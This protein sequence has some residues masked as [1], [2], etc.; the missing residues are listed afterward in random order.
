MPSHAECTRIG[1]SGPAGLNDSR[2][3]L[4]GR[5]GKRHVPAVVL[6]FHLVFWDKFQSGRVHTPPL[7]SALRRSVVEDV[8]TVR[9]GDL[10]THFGS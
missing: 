2:W 4:S 6:G 10:G 1:E 5:F 9:V 7:A 3:R 8:A